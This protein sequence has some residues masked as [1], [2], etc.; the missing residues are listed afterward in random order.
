VLNQPGS[1]GSQN[2]CYAIFV[3]RTD[4]NRDATAKINVNNEKR[5]ERQ[6]KKN[7][8]KSVPAEDPDRSPE[9]G[10]E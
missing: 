5:G 8:V 9:I 10:K 3:L 4:R 1:Y 6:P 7:W 2:V